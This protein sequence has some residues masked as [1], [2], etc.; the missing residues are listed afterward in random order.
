MPNW[1]NNE[2]TVTG[3]KESRDRFYN[4]NRSDESE[5]TF[6]KAVP[7]KEPT[8]ES[9][10]TTWGTKWDACD[11]QVD[12]EYSTYNFNTAWSPPEPWFCVIV[13]KYPN[14]RFTMQY[15]EPMMDF[16]GIMEGEDGEITEDISWSYSD[17]RWDELLDTGVV[18]QYIVEHA[19]NEFE[20]ILDFL[21]ERNYD[22]SYAYVMEGR[23]EQ[24][25]ANYAQEE[26]AT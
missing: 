7:E 5:L 9:H 23:I 18:E 20:D 13:E 17:I 8:C 19:S 11:V 4:E 14:L 1:C 2:L 6:A 16:E 26:M 24:F 22:D 12:H 25:R 15:S 3:D 21:S 10:Y